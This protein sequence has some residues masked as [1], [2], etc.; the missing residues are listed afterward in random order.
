MESA[1]MADLESAEPVDRE[2]WAARSPTLRIR[3]WAARLWEYWL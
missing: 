1:F 3:E 2:R